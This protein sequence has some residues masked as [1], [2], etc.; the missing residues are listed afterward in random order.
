MCSG[1]FEQVHIDRRRADVGTD[2]TEQARYR[3]LGVHGGRKSRNK[4]RLKRW[5]A[6]TVVRHAKTL[7]RVPCARTVLETQSLMFSI[8]SNVSYSM[9]NGVHNARREPYNATDRHRLLA[10]FLICKVE[11]RKVHDKA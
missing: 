2:L 8:L 9:Q 7:L 11:L 10:A 4:V 6:L 5:R 3:D 1:L